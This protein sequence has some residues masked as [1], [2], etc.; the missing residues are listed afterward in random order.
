MQRVR[1]TAAPGGQ[2]THHPVRR[3]L[4]GQPDEV[5]LDS[6]APRGEWTSTEACDCRRSCM[7]SRRG[8]SKCETARFPRADVVTA[9]LSLSLHGCRYASCSALQAFSRRTDPLPCIAR[10]S[11][12]GR[13]SYSLPDHSRGA[14]I[15]H[16]RSPSSSRPQRRP[17]ARCRR[18]S[19]QAHRLSIATSSWSSGTIACAPLPLPPLGPRTTP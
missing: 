3:S 19:T 8:Q 9:G 4:A 18:P 2:R 16:C 6:W 1:Q 14:S 10:R 5:E 11:M 12:S 17:S 15:P 13:D 7:R